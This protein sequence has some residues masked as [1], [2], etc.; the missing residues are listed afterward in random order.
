MTSDNQIHDKCVHYNRSR[1]KSGKQN[2]RES[3]IV[4][5][6]AK[7]SKSQRT[8]AP[9]ICPSGVILPIKTYAT[10]TWGLNKKIITKLQ[11]TPRAMERIMRG[12]SLRDCVL[13]ENSPKI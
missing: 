8:T 3:C 12:I 4:S 13:N 5:T 1:A 11:T 7:R 9:R 10:E 6:L 2:H